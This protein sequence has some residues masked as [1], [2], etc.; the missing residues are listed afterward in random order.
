MKAFLYQDGTQ[1]RIKQG[2]FPMESDLIGRT[3]VVVETD[4]YRP[5]RYGVVLDG[6]SLIRDFSEDELEPIETA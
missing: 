2:I 3:G 6:E 1:V 4:D 5:G